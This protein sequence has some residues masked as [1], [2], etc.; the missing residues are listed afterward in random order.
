MAKKIYM[1]NIK[2]GTGVTTCCVGLGFAL[3]SS[4][5]RTLIVDGDSFGGGAL[6]TGGC[7]NLQTYTLAD[8]EKGACRAKQTLV[9]HPK[10]TN[11]CFC[12]SIGLEDGEAAVRAVA[13]L[14]GLFDYILLDKAARPSC[15]SALIVTEPFAP[16]LKCSDVCRA[17]LTDGGIKDAGLIVNRLNGGQVISGE[18]MT[19]QEIAALLRLPLKAV[20]PE[21]LSIPLGKW[22]KQTTKAFKLAAESVT[23]K[24]EAICNVLLPYFGPAGF[25]KRKMR[26][27]I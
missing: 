8:Y 19:A 15:D 27:R 22:K 1:T 4:G 16:S 25:I 9:S 12:P 13:E 6:F 24:R 3:A 2:G 14:D 20:I 5:E 18:V 26:E 7:A 17:K 11:L 21:D 23:G 10:F